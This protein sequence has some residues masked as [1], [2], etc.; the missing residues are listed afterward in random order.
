MCYDRTGA[1]DRNRSFP[2][3]SHATGK[4]KLI[5]AG[6]RGGDDV[7]GNASRARIQS[8]SPA[9]GRVEGGTDGGVG[10]SNVYG[11]NM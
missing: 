8:D 9:G 10:I 6:L 3:P 11:Q 5:D 7:M 1:S 4:L 2:G